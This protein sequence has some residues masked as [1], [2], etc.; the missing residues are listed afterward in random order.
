[1]T[2]PRRLRLG[3]DGPSPNMYEEESRVAVLQ[4]TVPHYLP[5]FDAAIK[6]AITDAEGDPPILI[7][8]QDA[9]A[10]GYDDDE[11]TLLGM[12]VKYAGLHGVIVQIIGKNH[13]TF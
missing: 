11:Y 5:E 1:M 9:F 2:E 13:E 8:H 7:I 10:A 3:T 4:A 12:S 6:K